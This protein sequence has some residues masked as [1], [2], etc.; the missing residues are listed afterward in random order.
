MT[1]AVLPVYRPGYPYSDWTQC[2][3]PLC[4]DDVP[5]PPS[6]PWIQPSF[7]HQRG[8]LVV[9]AESEVVT[10]VFGSFGN[11]AGVFSVNLYVPPDPPPTPR[12]TAAFGGTLA[13]RGVFSAAVVKPPPPPTTIWQPTDLANT[14]TPYSR[15]SG[16]GFVR[17]EDVVGATEAA[18]QQASPNTPTLLTQALLANSLLN[19]AVLTLPK[20]EFRFPDGHSLPNAVSWGFGAIYGNSCK[21]LAGSGA[22]G[23]QNHP[24]K[25]VLRQLTTVTAGETATLIRL[26]SLQDPYFAGLSLIGNQT[27]DDTVYHTGVMVA[28]CTGR[29]VLEH[30]YLRGFSPGYASYP[31][32]ETFGLNI[33]RSN[34]TVLR[35]SETDG[36]DQAGHRT[37]AS[38]WGW[39]TVV[40]D[41]PNL[42]HVARC[43][44]HHGRCSMLTFWETTNITTQDYYS[45]SWASGTGNQGGAAINH[46]QSGGKIR[47]YRPRLFQNS[48]RSAG[49]V[50]VPPA[51]YGHPADDATK[52]N[53]TSACTFSMQSGLTDVGK[54]MEWWYPQWDNTVGNSGILCMA[55]YDGYAQGNALIN[56]PKVF[57]RKAD[58]SGDYQ[59]QV[60][61]HP[62]SG[63][64][65]LDPK[66]Y[67]AWIH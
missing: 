61:N 3:V 8:T 31:P 36:R 6:T 66:V 26:D 2:C 60:F 56:P 23:I 4:C 62:T 35:D 19:N 44:A 37:C 17:W 1:N 41:D 20:G 33:Y 59:L 34:N 53:N 47:H 21:G 10:T 25:T 57:L 16:Q 5:L 29:P 18:R 67:F 7:G 9:S 40:N 22:G 13:A 28:K 58:N 52:Q 63:W 42:V 15:P 32:G 12:V 11:R 55:G 48:T 64:N 49:P 54:D 51:A 27:R 30:L 38:P 24:S 43:Y 45:F 50:P 14:I 39:N 46:E 65:N